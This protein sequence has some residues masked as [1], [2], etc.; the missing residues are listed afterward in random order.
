[1]CVLLLLCAR[2]CVRGLNRRIMVTCF[3]YVFNRQLE[4]VRKNTLFSL[5][6]HHRRHYCDRDR[7]QDITYRIDRSIHLPAEH[8]SAYTHTLICGHRHGWQWLCCL[9]FTLLR[10]LGMR[11]RDR[12]N[13]IIYT[14][15][16]I[17]S[18]HKCTNPYLCRPHTHTHTR[19]H[20]SIVFI[21]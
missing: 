1:M 20:I 18:A 4:C 7:G 15:A 12:N 2:L 6:H 13:Y 11:C 10:T 8:E 16:T 14:D 5:G 19:L 17:N 9:T 3:V 21:V